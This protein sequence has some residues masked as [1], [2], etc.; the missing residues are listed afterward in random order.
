MAPFFAC[1]DN[2]TFGHGDD[3]ERDEMLV[4]VPTMEMM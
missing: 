3:E 1:V 4:P 2:V